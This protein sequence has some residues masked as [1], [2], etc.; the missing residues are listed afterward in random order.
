MRR[1]TRGQLKQV[2]Q[3]ESKEGSSSDKPSNDAQCGVNY[4]PLTC[5]N[6]SSTY[7]ALL[8]I[9]TGSSISESRHEQIPLPSL[10][11]SCC[12]YT[13]PELWVNQ[14]EIS[15]KAVWALRLRLSQAK[16]GKSTSRILSGLVLDTCSQEP[17]QT[18]YNSCL[19]I[20][21]RN[22]SRS[23]IL[24]NFIIQRHQILPFA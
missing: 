2:S 20:L 6:K 8:P 12:C 18:T 3:G 15:P 21:L 5:S 1:Y 9:E 22:G 19:T 23:K 13:E 14:A 16:I 7:D 17:H 10:D 4:D 11:L 24:C